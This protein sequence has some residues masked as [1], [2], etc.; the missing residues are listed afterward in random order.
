MAGSADLYTMSDTLMSPK[1]DTP[2]I[3]GGTAS[4]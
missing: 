1:P 2:G 3:S 4:P